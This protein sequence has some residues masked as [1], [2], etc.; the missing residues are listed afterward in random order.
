M[1][2]LSTVSQR[3]SQKLH[4]LSIFAQL[5]SHQVSG[6]LQ[7][8]S[9]STLWSI[10]L[11]QGKLS[12][13]TQSNAPFERLEVHLERLTEQAPKLVT[14]V[15]AKMRALFETQ[16]NQPSLITTQV[17]PD[18]RAIQWLIDENY[19]AEAQAQALIRELAQDVLESFLE[20]TEGRYQLINK[21][22]IQGYPSLCAFDLRPLVETCQISLRQRKA[23]EQALSAIAQPLSQSAASSELMT[24]RDTA[25]MAHPDAI[26]VEAYAPRADMTPTAMDPSTATAPRSMVVPT[27]AAPSTN[28]QYTIACI[29][30]SPTVLQAIKNFLEDTGVSVVMINDPVKALMQI[31][32]CKPDLILLDVGMPNLDGYE[33]CSLL[34]KNSNFK[35]I[36]I[37]MVTGNTGFIDRA[38]AKLVGATG[39]L[40]KPFTRSELN[41]MVFKHLP[42]KEANL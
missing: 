34:R 31:I 6:C 8:I 9:G 37:V 10:Y 27:S 25:P 13:A 17:S 15:R 40:T 33:L 7:V 35:Q 3:P 41:K 19:L 39:Y 5:I 12:F 38:K 22:Q 14:V 16:G 29:D 36:P 32:R 18:Y 2:T 20:V 4:P 24:A 23:S 1:N 26:A 11:D 21:V 42:V 28:T 30:D